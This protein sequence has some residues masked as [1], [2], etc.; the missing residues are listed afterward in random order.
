MHS[1]VGVLY[2]E[3]VGTLYVTVICLH[4][5]GRLSTV[6]RGVARNLKRGFLI[7]RSYEV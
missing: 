3:F 2:I 5:F 4:E 6:Y 7:E 1:F